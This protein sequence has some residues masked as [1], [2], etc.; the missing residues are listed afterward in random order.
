[1]LELFLRILNISIST[2]W[3]IL[4][5]LIFRSLLKKASKIF[6]IS[7]WG[8]VAVRLVL[9]HSV[10]SIFSLVPSAETIPMDNLYSSDL[11]IS[12]GIPAVDN[13]ITPI[14]NN[15]FACSIVT[16][17]NSFQL[18]IST[19]AVVWI[20]GILI[21]FTYLLISYFKVTKNIQTAVLLRENIYLS[22][23]ISSPFVFGLIKPK[24]YLPFSM[25]ESDMNYVISHE[26][27]HI[28]RKD[29]ILK[30][31]GFLL[32]IVYWF[33]PLVWISY[34]LLCRDIELACD[35]MV[36]KD[37]DCDSRADYSQTLL[38][39]ST[40][41]HVIRACPL[42]FGEVGVKNRIKTVI[43]Y[44]KP[45]FWIML[46]SVVLLIAVSLFFLTDPIDLE[47]EQGINEVSLERV[48]FDMLELNIDY[49]YCY[50]GYSIR[51]VPEDEGQYIGDGMI[52]Y[53]GSLGKY[54]LMIK[55]GDVEPDEA[56]RKEID[57]GS[58]DDSPIEVKAVIAYPADH[59]FV[60]YLGFDE[61]IYVDETM[62]KFINPF[63]GT[64]SIPVSLLGRS[65]D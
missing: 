31:F 41:K 50:G 30:P 33:N 38:R 46:V 26:F 1:M 51:V 60:L 58:L 62:G 32:V 4:A 45:K 59:G 42:A 15:S 35:E 21:L 48:S 7:L 14:I 63:R 10:K 54:R 44:K 61:P 17:M 24:I 2:S 19:L 27:A 56:F 36:I 20:V 34:V 12:S 16:D 13:A 57:G 23:N 8:L 22:E 39:F 9:P 6:S 47:R 52:D 37:L 49:S 28:K 11:A 3:M 29:H 40:N 55:F 25:S 18:L 5:V 53:D 64:I 43:T 65:S